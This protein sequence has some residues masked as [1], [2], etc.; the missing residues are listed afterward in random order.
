LK[1]FGGGE[2]LKER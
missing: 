1:R 2:K